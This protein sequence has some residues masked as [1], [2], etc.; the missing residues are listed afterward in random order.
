MPMSAEQNSGDGASFSARTEAI[1]LFDVSNGLVLDMSWDSFPTQLSSWSKGELNLNQSSNHFGFVFSGICEISHSTGLFRLH[2]G[3]YFSAPGA[4][5]LKGDGEGLII[6]SLHHKGFFHLGGPIEQSGRLNYIDGCTDSLLI[7]PVIFGDPCLNLLH[8]PLGITQTQHTH[9]SVRI[10]IVVRGRGE[11]V[12]PE[13]R[14]PLTPGKL[15][16]IPAGAIHSFVTAEAEM[17]IVAYHPDSD[18]G[19]THEAHPMLNRTIVDGVSAKFLD[20]IRTK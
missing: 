1:E 11:C 19:P 5:E 13:R 12:T 14:L 8:F 18:F 10:G 2:E 7:P 16:V 20:E 3:M 4:V 9:P 6:S 17:A 15:F